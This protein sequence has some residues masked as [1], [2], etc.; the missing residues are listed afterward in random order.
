MGEVHSSDELT[1]IP[2]EKDSNKTRGEKMGLGLEGLPSGVM[3]KE[4]LL[5]LDV[6]TLCSV[7]CVSTSL[8][9][10]VS[11]ALHLLSTLNLSVCF[12]LSLS[13]SLFL[14]PF[15]SFLF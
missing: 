4:V 8:R 1:Y 9:F 14:I 5:K 10:S 6:E 2:L 15:M 7:A 3:I 13:L 12:S 11:Q